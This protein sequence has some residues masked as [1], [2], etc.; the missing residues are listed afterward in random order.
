MQKILYLINTTWG[1]SITTTM[2][3][4]AIILLARK[5]I[6]ARINASVKFEYDKKLANIHSKLRAQEQEFKSQIDHNRTSLE[7]ISSMALDGASLRQ[8]DI[9]KRQVNGIE[10]LW[11]VISSYKYGE[12]QVEMVERINLDE[13]KTE[14]QKENLKLIVSSLHDI[15]ENQTE[16][17]KLIDQYK[18]FIPD[19]LWEFFSAYRQI[20][21]F[22][23]GKIMLIKKGLYDQLKKDFD[24]ETINKIIVALPEYQDTVKEY[25]SSSFP[26]IIEILNE[27]MLAEAKRIL[28]G[29]DKD[30]E[31][32]SRASFI[33][34][35]VQELKHNM[36]DPTTE[37]SLPLDLT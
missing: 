31:D 21:H 16:E 34:E 13:I 35:A 15:L 11:A 3:F 12:K 36:V 1:A 6:I 33:Q 7:S 29:A 32:I 24:K 14:Q 26:A 27:K 2:V 4:S 18:P 8:G 23:S 28:C 9:F 37:T 22:N 25:G 19:K 10:R 17:S 20:I 30:K 5:A